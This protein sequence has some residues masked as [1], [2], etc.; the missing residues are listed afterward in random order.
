MSTR[1]DTIALLDRMFGPERDVDDALTR[2]ENATNDLSSIVEYVSVLARDF[3]AA[4]Q[5]EGVDLTALPGNV[6]PELD[7]GIEWAREAT[8]AACRQIDRA[9]GDVGATVQRLGEVA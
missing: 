6:A 1:A 9:V 4:L 3:I 2:I 5:A 7:E 8:D